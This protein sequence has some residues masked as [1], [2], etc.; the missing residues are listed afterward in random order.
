MVFKNKTSLLLAA[1][2]VATFGI[3]GVSEAGKPSVGG[4]CQKCHTAQPDA[5]R[6]NLGKVSPE[7][8]TLQVSAGKLVWIVKYDD[9]TSIIDGD[10]TSGAEALKQLPQ[11]K[12]ILVSYSGGEEKPLA[13]EIRVKQPYK[14]PEE[15]KITNDEVVNLVAMGPEQGKYTLVDARPTGAFLTG[16]IPTAISLPFDSFEENCSTVLP[17]NKDSLI[18]FYCGGPT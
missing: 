8:K 5:V 6:G 15:Q 14:I 10:K 16:H 13:S 12:E 7:F 1:I 4:P 9:K 18:V 2:V 17:N 11:G 3:T